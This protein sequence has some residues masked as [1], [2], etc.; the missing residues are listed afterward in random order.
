MQSTA[1]ALRARLQK[2]LKGKKAISLR[3]FSRRSKVAPGWLSVFVKGGHV[4]PTGA[5]LDKI[6]AG[7]RQ[8]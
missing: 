8:R 5:T 2:R 7:L 1:A 6:R 4:N 3:E